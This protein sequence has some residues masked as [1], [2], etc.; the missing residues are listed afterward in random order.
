M[1][2]SEQST[3]ISNIYKSRGVILDQLSTQG[4]D[5]SNYNEFSVNEV[6]L[7][8][9]HQQ[10]DMLLTNNQTNK[11]VL[12][13]Y[14]IGKSTHDKN[15]YETKKLND[16]TIYDLVED[17]Y[18]MEQ[19][20]SKKDTLIIISKDDPTPSNHQVLRHLYSNDGIFII[21]YSLKRLQYNILNHHIVPKH[22]ILDATAV[23]DFH[24]RFGILTDSQIPDI[25]RFDPI[26]ISI[27]LKPGDICHILR[28]SKIA[29]LGDYYRICVNI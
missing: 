15:V 12:V 8:Y 28:P 26:A 17:L 5:V 7:M 11:K 3:H 4:Y 22:T 29:V 9:Q 10:L 21:I 23:E 20:L 24:K 14:N 13:K 25:S 6:N 18:N 19:I 16:K 1:K 2:A 27:G